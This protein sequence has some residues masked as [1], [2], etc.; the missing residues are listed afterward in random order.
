MSKESASIEELRDQL[1]ADKTLLQNV[2]DIVSRNNTGYDYAELRVQEREEVDELDYAEEFREIDKTVNLLLHLFERHVHK[3]L[4][5]R[6][7]ELLFDLDEI[8]NKP[9]RVFRQLAKIMPEYAD[10][11]TDYEAFYSYGGVIKVRALIEEFKK[12]ADYKESG[13]SEKSSQLMAKLSTHKTAKNEEDE[14]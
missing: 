13:F 6:E 3:A 8:D 4:E 11:Y 7:T 12:T 1:F 10:T 9:W 2:R 5:A 14:R